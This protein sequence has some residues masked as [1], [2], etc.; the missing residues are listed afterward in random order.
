MPG[1]FS[2][3]TLSFLLSLPALLLLLSCLYLYFFSHLTA[4]MTLLKLIIARTECRIALFFKKNHNRSQISIM[5]AG[6]LKTN[7]FLKFVLHEYK[8]V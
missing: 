5:A 7:T 4:T 8:C 2:S 6:G 3:F 1:D